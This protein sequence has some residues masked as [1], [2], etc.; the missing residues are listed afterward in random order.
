MD[1]ADS[2]LGPNSAIRWFLEGGWVDSPCPQ[3]DAWMFAWDPKDVRYSY[4]HAYLFNRTNRLSPW[5]SV[6]QTCLQGA[7]RIRPFRLHNKM[8]VCALHVADVVVL[9]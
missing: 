2:A 7:S 6:E 1:V 8:T 4:G 3:R 5:P 9:S